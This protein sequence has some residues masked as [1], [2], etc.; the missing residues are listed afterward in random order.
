MNDSF[1]S[2]PLLASSSSESDDGGEDESS[3]VS[4]DS[5]DMVE[6]SEDTSDEETFYDHSA[7][8]GCFL[9]PLFYAFMVG[10]LTY[11]FHIQTLTF[12]HVLD[13]SYS[14]LVMDLKD[15]EKSFKSKSLD[16]SILFLS[17][18]IR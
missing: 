13:H 11:L 8:F 14:Y 3:G 9:V 10:K 5:D 18:D 16:F 7:G 4:D 12:I 1:L 2:R 6:S 17:I 15:L